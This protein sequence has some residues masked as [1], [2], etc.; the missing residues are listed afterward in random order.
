[1]MTEPLATGFFPEQWK[2]AIEVMLEKIL[3]GVRSNKL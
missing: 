1:M 3:G 2:T